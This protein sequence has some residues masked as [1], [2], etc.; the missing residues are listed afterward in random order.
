MPYVTGQGL[1][2]AL[3]QQ[4]KPFKPTFHLGEMVTTI[5]NVGDP[6]FRIGTTGGKTFE[7]KAVVIAAGGGSFQPKR[8][9]IAGIEPY[10]A[11]SVFYAVRKMDEFR[12]KRLLIVGGGDSAL[13]WTL[14]LQPVAKRLTLLHRRDEFRGAPDSVNKMRALVADGKMDLKV[15]QVSALEGDDGKLCRRHRQG[16]RRHD[17][18][19]SSSTP[20]CRFSA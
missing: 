1:T 14:N 19:A 18:R 6:L 12:G 5:E 17:H 3:M 13:D 4:I 8:P 11:K 2:D 9:P 20:C 16:Q 10:E 15:G 7:A